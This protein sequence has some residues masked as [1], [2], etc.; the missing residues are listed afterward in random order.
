MASWGAPASR[1]SP[2]AC[3]CRLQ[4]RALAEVKHRLLDRNAFAVP[5]RLYLIGGCR[6]EADRARAAALRT[7]AATLDISDSV[8]FM[9][10]APFDDMLRALGGAAAGLHTM[11]DE[12]FG[13]G[14]VEYMAAG[15]VPVAHDSGALSP[16]PPA[17]SVGVRC[18]VKHA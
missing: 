1:D 13:I 2:H 5:P 17:C 11:T 18:R 7:L 9:V 3:F 10:N 14:V 8:E 12:H 15:C 6:H 4:L 16:A